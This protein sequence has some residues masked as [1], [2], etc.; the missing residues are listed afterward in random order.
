MSFLLQITVDTFSTLEKIYRTC[1]LLLLLLT[2][3]WWLVSEDTWSH[4]DILHF[5]QRL[6]DT[7]CEM[8]EVLLRS[9]YGKDVIYEVVILLLHILLVLVANG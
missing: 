5:L 1:A 9:K 7:C 3:I 8:A 2:L 4:S 6:I